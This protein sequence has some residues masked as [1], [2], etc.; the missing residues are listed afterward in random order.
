MSDWMPETDGVLVNILADLS[1][2][3]VERA[4]AD[5]ELERPD[6]ANAVFTKDDAVLYR[7]DAEW[8][9]QEVQSR[10]FA[11]Q[12]P[13]AAVWAAIAERRAHSPLLLLG[14]DDSELESLTAT[15]TRCGQ[16]KEAVQFAWIPSRAK[17]D[18]WCK[19]CRRDNWRACELKRKAA[20]LAKK[21][22]IA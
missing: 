17:L 6:H 5:A 3:V 21:R 2:A 13:M 20:R 10:A 7:R 16:T 12:D 11:F 18:S 1:A 9:L 14:R 15:C 8:F 22:G 4:L 19:D